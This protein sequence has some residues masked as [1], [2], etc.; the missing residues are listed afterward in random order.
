MDHRALV[1]QVNRERAKAGDPAGSLITAA[2]CLDLGARGVRSLTADPRKDGAFLGIAGLVESGGDF[3]LF[4]WTP[5]QAPRILGRIPT[6]E[7]TSPEA[8]VVWMDEGALAGRIL[9]D[10]GT[11]TARDT[12][13]ACADVL[14]G[15]CEGHPADEAYV[16]VGSFSL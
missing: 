12:G 11:R 10:E 4:A 6:P 13:C 15:S 8:L 9:F 14:A 5:G 7:H 16:R 1:V 3:D 2:W